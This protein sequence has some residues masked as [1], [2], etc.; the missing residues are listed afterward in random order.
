VK[1][2]R[3]LVIQ[4]T[5][6]E[7]PGRYLLD[8]AGESGAEL[9][10]CRAWEEALPNPDPFDGLIGLGGPPNVDEEAHYPYLIPLKRLI[11]SWVAQRRP[12]LGFCL[13]HQLLAHVLRAEVGPQRRSVGFVGAELTAAGLAHPFFKGWPKEVRLFKWHGQGVRLPLPE[14]LELLAQSLACPV[15]AFGLRGVPQ[16]VGMQFDLHAANEADA[17]KWL[18]ADRAWL[19]RTGPNAEAVDAAAVIEEARE[20]EA[21][22]GRLF[23]L[24][25]KNFCELV[26]SRHG[27]VPAR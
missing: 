27:L 9:A 2:L 25:W 13:G 17:A 12:Y 20:R 14:G 22:S 16:V 18:T 3:F 11:R 26:A 24:L 21:E 7:G 10:V 19:S 6:W 8:A 23:G 1:A 5:A 4:H 15:E